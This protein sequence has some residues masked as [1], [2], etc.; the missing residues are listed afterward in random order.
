MKDERRTLNADELAASTY[1]QPGPSERIGVGPLVV[2]QWADHSETVDLAGGGP[3][4]VTTS[5]RL[6]FSR[7][8][9]RMVVAEYRVESPSASGPGLRPRDLRR[10]E[11]QPLMIETAD[12]CVV[13]SFP[14]MDGE[15]TIW[16]KAWLSRPYR[17]VQWHLQLEDAPNVELDAAHKWAICHIT[18]R[19]ANATIAEA[20]GVSLSTAK[21]HVARARELGYIDL[22]LG[23]QRGDDQ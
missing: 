18:G 19:N 9:R 4:T 8:E 2:N 14:R 21:R 15:V 17:P 1:T 6:E 7:T 20:Y 11:L 5:V 13:T 23:V 22:M 3:K 16:A 10:I 12:F